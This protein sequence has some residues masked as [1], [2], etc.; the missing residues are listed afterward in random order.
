MEQIRDS[1]SNAQ[2]Y[3]EHTQPRVEQVSTGCE[4]T[5]GFDPEVR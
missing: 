4:G 5:T 2:D 1:Q 3:R